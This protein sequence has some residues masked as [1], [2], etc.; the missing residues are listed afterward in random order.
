MLF[1]ISSLFATIKIAF[2]CQ[3]LFARAHTHVDNEKQLTTNIINPVVVALAVMHNIVP[4]KKKNSRKC[5]G[6]CSGT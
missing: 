3:H 6:I 2:L 5:R 1:M 4:G